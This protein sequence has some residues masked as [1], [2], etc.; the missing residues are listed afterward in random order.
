MAVIDII[1]SV[2]SYLTYGIHGNESWLQCCQVSDAE[3]LSIPSSDIT[4]RAA[5]LSPTSYQICMGC[6]NFDTN[7][8]GIVPTEISV[9]VWGTSNANDYIYLARGV[10]QDVPV[11]SDYGVIRAIGGTDSLGYIDDDDWYAGNWNEFV[12]LRND[13]DVFNSTGLTKLQVRLYTDIWNDGSWPPSTD[14]KTTIAGLGD[15]LH[16]PFMRVS[17]EI[18]HADRATV[19]K[20]SAILNGELLHLGGSASS[21]VSF[22]YGTVKGGPYTDF[23]TPEVKSSVGSFHAD[24]TGLTPGERYYVRAKSWDYH[25][26]LTIVPYRLFWGTIDPRGTYPL[27]SETGVLEVQ[28]GS[29]QSFTLTPALGKHVSWCYLDGVV[30]DGEHA[31][32]EVVTYTF[33]DIQDDHTI[34]M[35]F[36]S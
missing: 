32:D 22:E 10:H 14:Y 36:D 17:Y 29:N 6:L 1:A 28:P 12:L 33:T 26:T 13:L 25:Y 20:Y 34:T 16:T 7:G 30:Y 3:Q 4:L 2:T 5:K 31:V 8:L 23:T 11:V 18:V 35:G 9:F 24:I 27:D 21:E 19:S 15:P